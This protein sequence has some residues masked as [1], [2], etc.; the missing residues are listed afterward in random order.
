MG[1]LKMS[2]IHFITIGF[3]EFHKGQDVLIQ[4]VRAL[5]EAVLAECRFT[6]VGNKSSLFAQD[7]E[8]Q[9]NDI[10]GVE[11]IGLVDR[12]EIHRLLSSADVLICPSRED[13]MPTVCAE[14]M[15]HKLPCLVSDA[16]GTASYIED[17]YNGM[18]FKSEDINTLKDEINWCI[19]NISE[20]RKMGERSFDIYK[21]YF[22]MDAFE[23]NLLKY[24]EEMI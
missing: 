2:R 19:E 5:N 14:A 24:V 12:D 6:I 18:I 15:M 10:S 13:S 17:R 20:I 16:I 8:K 22:S 23:T 4:A 3:V 9:I 21:H 7:L 11:M 1:F